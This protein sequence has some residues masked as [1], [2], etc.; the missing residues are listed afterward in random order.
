VASINAPVFTTM[1]RALGAGLAGPATLP[2][3]TRRDPPLSL[4]MAAR[5]RL[6]RV[7]PGW[8]APRMGALGRFRPCALRPMCRFSARDK[9][10][11]IAAMIFSS[12]TSFEYLERLKRFNLIIIVAN[13]FIE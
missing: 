7:R 2:D 6:R 13:V 11:T 10:R 1:A 5:S 3:A 12:G 8:S 4:A 9:R